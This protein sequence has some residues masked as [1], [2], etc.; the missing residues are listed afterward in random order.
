MT[1]HVLSVQLYP[2]HDSYTSLEKRIIFVR[3]TLATNSTLPIPVQI[4]RLN[5]PKNQI[6]IY[7]TC[8]I[9]TSVANTFDKSLHY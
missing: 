8:Y 9:E 5:H 3:C 1:Q 4:S 6:N 7:Y 2:L